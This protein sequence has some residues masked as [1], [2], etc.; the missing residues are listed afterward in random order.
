MNREIAYRY[1]TEEEG[2]VYDITVPFN[3]NLNEF[4]NSIENLMEKTG[5][6][7]KNG[8]P[9]YEF[10]IVR[11]HVDSISGGVLKIIESYKGCWIARPLDENADENMLLINFKTNHTMEAVGNVFLNKELVFIND[12]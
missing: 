5:Y 10:D 9:L 11:H 6:I 3:V 1:Y 8:N 4:L 12:D 2:M 7:D